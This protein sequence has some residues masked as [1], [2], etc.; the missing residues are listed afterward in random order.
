MMKRAG[1]RDR[2]VRRI[3]IWMTTA[4]CWGPFA[5]KSMLTEG[6]LAAEPDDGI[7]R[8]AIAPTTIAHMM[9]RPAS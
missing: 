6:P 3:K 4:V 8:I 5:P 9:I 1:A 7:K 2:T